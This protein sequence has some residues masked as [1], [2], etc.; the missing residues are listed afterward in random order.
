MADI[1]LKRAY[2]PSSPADGYRVYVDRL[3]P[4]GLSH[5]TFHYDS[6][7][8]AIAPSTELR[9]WFHADPDGRWDEFEA[10]Y[11][12]ELRENPAFAE[13]KAEIKGKPVVTLLFSSH[14][15]VRNN[16]VVVRKMLA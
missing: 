7:D 5:S 15:V 9:E 13:L 3:W 14:D 8:K 11:E 16:A 4:R 2:E 6:W 10:R 12:A 1:R